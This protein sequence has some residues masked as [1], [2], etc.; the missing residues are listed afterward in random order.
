[1]AVHSVVIISHEMFTLHKI[2]LASQAKWDRRNGDWWVVVV[3]PILRWPHINY[4]HRPQHPHI[5]RANIDNSNLWWVPPTPG[6]RSLSQNSQVLSSHVISVI[7]GKNHVY[8]THWHW[9]SGGEKENVVKY[10]VWEELLSLMKYSC[11]RVFISGDI[12]V[13]SIQQ[14]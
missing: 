2:N 1:M 11:G 12:C 4:H 5:K 13:T 3:S 8:T 7:T 6:W 10:Y 14:A 9:I